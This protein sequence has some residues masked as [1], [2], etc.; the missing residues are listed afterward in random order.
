MDMDTVLDRSVVV[1]MGYHHGVV[2][3]T[4]TKTNHV[5]SVGKRLRLTAVATTCKKAHIFLYYV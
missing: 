3:G 2:Y 1:G 4:P 5:K